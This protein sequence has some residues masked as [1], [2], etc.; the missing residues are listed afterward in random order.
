[1]YLTCL[2]QLSLLNQF[3][4]LLIA[5]VWICCN[6]FV[7][8][9]I[10]NHLKFFW[11]FTAL[12]NVAVCMLREI[13]LCAHARVFLRYTLCCGIYW[14]QSAYIFKCMRCCQPMSWMLSSHLQ[15]LYHLVFRIV[16]CCQEDENKMCS[17]GIFISIALTT[18]E[19]NPFMSS[20]LYS[21]HKIFAG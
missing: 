7:P 1:M 19:R 13:L 8:F 12:R 2:L 21:G 10:L 3:I 20:L 15:S 9:F 5:T 4:N 16:N 6:L 18:W 11:S 17:I 14:S